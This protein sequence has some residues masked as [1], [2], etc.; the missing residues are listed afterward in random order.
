[1]ILDELDEIWINN[2]SKRELA[3]IGNITKVKR[4]GRTTDRLPATAPWD[5]AINAG[6]WELN[7]DNEMLKGYLDDWYTYGDPV[8]FN[9]TAL[10][11]RASSSTSPDD[12]ASSDAPVEAADAASDVGQTE[13]DLASGEDADDLDVSP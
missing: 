13:L 1:V 8:G 4:T 5:V 11:S 2:R 12:P 10:S 9:S 3:R 6:W 7:K